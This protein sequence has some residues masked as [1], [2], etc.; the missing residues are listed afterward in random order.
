MTYGLFAS[1][2]PF[3]T[4]MTASTYTHRTETVASGIACRR[5]SASS[6][7]RF[8]RRR[9]SSLCGPPGPKRSSYF[10][11]SMRL[12][13]KAWRLPITLLLNPV[14]MATMA[15]T[16]VTPTTIPRMV[17]A[18]RSFCSRTDPSAKSTL[19]EKP[20]WKAAR[21]AATSGL[22][23][24][25]TPT[26]PRSLMA[27]GL[28]GSEA[29]RGCGGRE[30][31]HEAGQ[32]AGQDPDGRERQLHLRREDLADGQGHQRAAHHAPH[33]A[34]HGQHRRFLKELPADVPLA[35]AQR[36]AQPDLLRALQHGDEHDVG[37]HDPAH[38]QRDP[39]DQ[40]HHREGGGGD[41]APERLDGFRAH[42]PERIVGRER[43]PPQRAQDGS[44]LA[45][46][47]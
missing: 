36:H 27:Q 21:T 29:C 46:R 7:V 25:T 20:R 41:G 26:V 37:D 38:H 17:S 35:R 45:F 40:D 3:L 18:E 9:S 19:A 31:G 39:R 8:F 14:T 28:H 22:F 15:I 10:W 32:R 4:W 6:A 23:G 47:L 12:A 2:L 42:D 33:A 5:A 43:R 11:I 13:P 34:E 30:A 24:W 16:V 1:T 44:H